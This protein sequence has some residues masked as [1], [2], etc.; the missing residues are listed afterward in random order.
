MTDP[1]AAMLTFS[2]SPSAAIAVVAGIISL[3][4]F[5]LGPH[6]SLKQEVAEEKEKLTRAANKIDLLEQ[7]DEFHMKQI[8]DN[9]ESHSA[10]YS[11]LRT[12]VQSLGKKIDD[13]IAQHSER[14]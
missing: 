9:K 2:F 12:D 1:S 5:V 6:R 13:F 10:E 8:E 14:G 7:S 3:L 4:I 11:G